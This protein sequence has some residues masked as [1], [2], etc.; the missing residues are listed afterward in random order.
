MQKPVVEER[1]EV[2]GNKY[3]KKVEQILSEQS[4]LITRYATFLEINYSGVLVL[5]ERII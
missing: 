2:V 4:I 5:K 3:V 1:Q